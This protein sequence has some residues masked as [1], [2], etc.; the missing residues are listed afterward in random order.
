MGLWI[1]AVVALV[2][3]CFAVPVYLGAPYLPTLS[4]HR[5][6]LLD[7]SGIERGQTVVDLGCGDG[8]FL[9]AAAVRGVRGIGYEVNP[10]LWAVSKVVLWSRRDLVSVRFGD[11]RRHPL[12]EADLVYVFLRQERMAELAAKVAA[13]AREPV[14]LLSYCYTVPDRTPCRSLPY[15]HLYCFGAERGHGHA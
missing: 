9:R 13:E 11:Y 1:W 6:E 5:E 3:S 4:R 14:R 7:F 8:R 2:A 15:A 10:V 12:P